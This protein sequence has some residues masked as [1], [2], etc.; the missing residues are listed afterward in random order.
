MSAHKHTPGEWEIIPQNGGSPI[1]GRR[2]NTGNQMNPIGIRLVCQ[3][4][5]RGNSIQED[6][7]NARLIAA[8]PT[9]YSALLDAIKAIDGDFA[10]ES[11]R[12]DA[13]MASAINMRAAIAKATGETKGQP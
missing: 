12:H 2:F 7:A 11:E 9:M 10:F 4:F 3:V 1:I 13:L 8:A 5:A 6:D